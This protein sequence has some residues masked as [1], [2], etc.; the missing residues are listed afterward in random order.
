ME[1]GLI[2]LPLFGYFAAIGG[3]VSLV[4]PQLSRS[5]QTRG[6]LLFLVL[7]ALSLL[8]TWTYMALYFRHSFREAA[9]ER[10]IEP[11]EFSTKQ[12]LDDVSLFNEAWGYVCETTERFWWSEQLMYWTT[13]PLAVLMSVEGES[14]LSQDS[15]P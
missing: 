6:S 7:A 4:A 9:G 5:K 15:F 1:L 12:W 13:G 8:S 11:A 10:G 2:H 14:Q 3:L